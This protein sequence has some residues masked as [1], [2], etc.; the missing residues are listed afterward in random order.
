MGIMDGGPDEGNTL[1]LALAMGSMLTRMAQARG[2]QARDNLAMRLNE[3][4]IGKK[5]L[6]SSVRRI[7][8]WAKRTSSTVEELFAKIDIDGSGSVDVKEFRSG[9]SLLGLKFDDRE[10]GVLVEHMD[11]SGDGVLDT[12]E[13][14][15]KMTEMLEAEATS[16]SSILSTFCHYLHTSGET[17]AKL[18]GEL[19]ADGAKSASN[20]PQIGLKLA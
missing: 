19:D 3:E 5:L 8:C 18:F 11:E 15:L 14:C 13:F 12:G 10:L 20:R 9:M 6:L 16:G 1:G 7:Y 4:L 2:T 17:A